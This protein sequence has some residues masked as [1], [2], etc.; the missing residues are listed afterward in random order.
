[1]QII[2]FPEISATERRKTGKVTRAVRGHRL[3]GGGK[4]E[5]F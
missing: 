5:R 1:M 3:G 4:E 2:Y